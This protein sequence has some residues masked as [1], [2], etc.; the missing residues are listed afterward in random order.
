MKSKNVKLVYPI[1]TAY[2]QD[3]TP[4]EALRELI[5][6]GLDGN[7]QFGALFA[8]AYD[9]KK[10]LL[11]LRNTDVKLP[12][13]A[14]FFGGSDKVDDDALI[15]RYGEGL[16]L[17]LLVLK[18]F[19]MRVTIENADEAW[20][21]SFVGLHG[22]QVLQVTVK[23]DV[24]ENADFVVR[25]H[26]VSKELWAEV[27]AL[28]LYLDGAPDLLYSSSSGDILPD[29]YAGR[30]Y[31]QGVFCAYVESYLLGYNL[32]AP[33]DSG[34]DRRA[35]SS[36]ALADE[37]GE[38]LGAWGR[39]SV[40]GSEESALH[41]DRVE[42]LYNMLAEGSADGEAL[43]RSGATYGVRKA[44]IDFWKEKHGDARPIGDESQADEWASIGVPTVK[45]HRRLASVL[46]YYMPTYEQS[47]DAYATQVTKTYDLD[48][49]RPDEQQVHFEVEKAIRVLG[50]ED[51]TVQYVDFRDPNTVAGPTA[52]GVKIARRLLSSPTSAIV[53]WCRELSKKQVSYLSHAQVSIHDAY[54]IR[55]M[56]E[57]LRL[58]SSQSVPSMGQSSSA[59]VPTS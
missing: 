32:K 46:S 25:V 23:P 47:R 17:A 55:A 29:A 35:P 56:Q 34:R 6:N 54:V 27:K 8:H 31:I 43:V 9:P 22:Q 2:V 18:R 59:Q 15:G 40:P 1:K 50:V 10:R 28:F 20:V 33:L 58:R 38:L 5:A 12:I 26:G 11:E 48:A 3:W 21:P 16:K 49:L 51:N 53:A 45:C 4:K 57:L 19:D 42:R 14:L 52:D 36:G 41:P 37:V 44:L 13:D 39:E 7:K 24:F 30:I